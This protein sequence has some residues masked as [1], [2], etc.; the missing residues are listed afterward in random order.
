MIYFSM[1]DEIYQRA[2]FTCKLSWGWVILRFQGR[3]YTY[4]RMFRWTP[5]VDFFFQIYRLIIDI[6]YILIVEQP[7][8]K[9][10][11]SI[12]RS[13]KILDE[14]TD[15]T[16][17]E[18][19]IYDAMQFVWSN[20]HIICIELAASMRFFCWPEITLQKSHYAHKRGVVCGKN[21]MYNFV[22]EI[23]SIEWQL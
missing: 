13:M 5:F 9:N 15:F 1:E 20:I 12:S 14:N 7:W 19:V 2:L 21:L 17:A 8:Y 6:W 23:L 4:S 10:H 16:T 22:T 18:I 3:S 11:P